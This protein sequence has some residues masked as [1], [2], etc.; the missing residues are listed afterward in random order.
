MPGKAYRKSA[1]IIK[2]LQNYDGFK[3]LEGN[4]RQICTK[5]Q[6]PIDYID[7]ASIYSIIETVLLLIRHII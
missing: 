2:A 1:M 5:Y 7:L 4:N 3:V 6:L